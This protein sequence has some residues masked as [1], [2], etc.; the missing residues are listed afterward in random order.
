MKKI[1]KESL[2]TLLVLTLIIGIIPFAEFDFLS[3]CVN[4]SAEENEKT[5]TQNEENIEFST[6]SVE[7]LT[8]SMADEFVEAFLNVSATEAEKISGVL[9]GKETGTADELK[10]I[11]DRCSVVFGASSSSNI[12]LSNI[13]IANTI[14]LVSKV[15]NIYD[16]ISDIKN[17]SS[18]FYS[19]VSAI[20]AGVSMLGL[21]NVPV[22]AGLEVVIAAISATQPIADFIAKATF[23]EVL[24]FYEIDL[25][26]AYE[27]D[28]EL[29]LPPEGRKNIAGFSKEEQE[30]LYRSVYLQDLCLMWKNNTGVNAVKK[31]TKR[32]LASLLAVVMVLT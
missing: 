5:M 13:N 16:S 7:Y 26:M 1:V 27:L 12:S 17:S 29:P 22:G 32:I 6:D 3:L 21:F 30:Q 20:Q 18:S 2:A 25:L 4:V 23:Q 9:V 11:I 10:L 19:F 31:T 15:L 8:E 28:E 24:S 14:N